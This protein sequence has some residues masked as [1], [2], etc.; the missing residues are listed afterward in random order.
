MAHQ[1]TAQRLPEALATV[2]GNVASIGVFRVGG[3]DA[4]K[5]ES[6]MTPIFK[7]KDMINLGAQE[8]YIKMTIDGE[9]YD[10]FSAETLKV[11]PAT[12]QSLKKRIIDSSR[13]KYSV[14]TEELKRKLKEEEESLLFGGKNPSPTLSSSG[15]SQPVVASPVVS[16]E[17]APPEPLI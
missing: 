17:S 6:E 15:I 5:L 13:R 14:K 7:A 2:V 11:L 12:H 1:Y 4:E 8:F 3:D 16:T 9:T 10:P